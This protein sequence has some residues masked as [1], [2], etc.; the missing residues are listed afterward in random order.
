MFSE[1]QN[2][3]IFQDNLQKNCNDYNSRSLTKQNE[4]DASEHLQ[5]NCKFLDNLQKSC[6]DYD[7][8][9]LA[10]QLY[11]YL[12]N[13]YDVYQL[14]SISLELLYIFRSLAEQLQPLHISVSSGLT[15]RI[16]KSF[17]E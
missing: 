12:K 9:P 17:L 6:N 14:F 4:C 16:H 1:Q 5:N 15:G 2:N 13:N 11:I 7:S 10:G 8:R 3:C